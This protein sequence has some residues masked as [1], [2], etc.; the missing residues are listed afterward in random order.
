MKQVVG[1]GKT[2]SQ[3]TDVS[4]GQSTGTQ[5]NVTA[6]GSFWGSGASTGTNAANIK[7]IRKNMSEHM[8]YIFYRQTYDSFME[9]AKT[10][11]KKM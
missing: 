9:K 7:D 5:S 8:L 2:I 4:D 1:D 3:G 11:A 6:G 10:A